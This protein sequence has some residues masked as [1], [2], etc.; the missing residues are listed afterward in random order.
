MTFSRYWL[1]MTTGT[2]KKDRERK[3]KGKLV[4]ELAFFLLFILLQYF[5]LSS[6]CYVF[7]LALLQQFL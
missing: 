7:C 2:H 6:A 1:D 4:S 5:M 3:E